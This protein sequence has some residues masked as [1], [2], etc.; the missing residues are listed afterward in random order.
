MPLVA[1]SEQRVCLWCGYDLRGQPTD[2]PRCPE[3]GTAFDPGLPPALVEYYL[4]V[5]EHRLTRGLA[6]LVLGGVWLGFMASLALVPAL[7][8]VVFAFALPGAYALAWGAAGVVRFRTQCAAR[9][10]WLPGLLAFYGWTSLHAALLI[11]LAWAAWLIVQTVWMPLQ[12]TEP[13]LVFG[14]WMLLAL[15]CVVLHFWVWGKVSRRRHA[16]I[17]PFLASQAT[18]LARRR[19][20]ADLTRNP[21]P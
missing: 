21:E 5:L 10:G 13:S 9:P 6:A 15:G 19:V 12:R 14:L 17:T 20:Q 18:D 7:L 4:G 3:C 11:L 8:E 2:A 16:R 1:G